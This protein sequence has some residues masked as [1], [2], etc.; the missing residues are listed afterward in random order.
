[1]EKVATLLSSQQM[2]LVWIEENIKKIREKMDSM[3][4]PP[5]D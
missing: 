4:P 3:K 1:M 5:E 2:Q